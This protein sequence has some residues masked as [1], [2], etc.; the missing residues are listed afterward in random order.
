M[1]QLGTLYQYEIKKILKRK[2]TWI[3]FCG[4]M[5]IIVFLCYEPLLD[6]YTTTDARTGERVRSTKYDNVLE[7]QD[8]AE[9]LN[10]RIID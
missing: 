8:W 5:L 7:R 9:R 4:V 3:A 6:N 10:G 1:S 2:M